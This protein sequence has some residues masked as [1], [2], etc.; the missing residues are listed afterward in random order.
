MGT[1]A[2]TFPKSA[3]VLNRFSGRVSQNVTTICNGYG[4][5]AVAS[6]GCFDFTLAFYSPVEALHFISVRSTMRRFSASGLF[7]F[8]STSSAARRPI[9][10]SDGSTVVSF[11]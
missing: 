1:F 11:G 9:S 10:P 6:Y 7:T 4:K 3:N 5:N 2:E 8:S